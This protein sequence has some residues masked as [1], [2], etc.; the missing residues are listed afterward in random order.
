MPPLHPARFIL[1]HI[2]AYG[3]F[4]FFSIARELS[5]IVLPAYARISY[6]A[7]RRMMDFLLHR[8]P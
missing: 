4:L 7:S 5:S 8:L 1:L 3:L 6:E 2:I